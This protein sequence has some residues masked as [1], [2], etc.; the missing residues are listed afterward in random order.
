MTP[1]RGGS[2]G[3]APYGVNPKESTA[4]QGEIGQSQEAKGAD[5]KTRLDQ[6]AELL[7]AIQTRVRATKPPELTAEL[8]S[9]TLHQLEAVRLVQP[10]G[11]MMSQLAE[12]LDISES[13]ATALVDRLVRHGLIERAEDPEDRRVVRIIPSVRSRDLADRFVVHQRRVLEDAFRVLDDRDLG[14]LV[15]LLDQVVARFTQCEAVE[16]TGP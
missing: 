6:L 2:G 8:G 15:D 5:R 7:P 9:V 3:I 10:D 12:A 1:S 4:G 13:A 14:V 11:L 16:G